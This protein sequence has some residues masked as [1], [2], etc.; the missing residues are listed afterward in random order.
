M[1]DY[2]SSLACL[3]LAA[4]GGLC[5]FIAYF[6]GVELDSP[7]EQLRFS[8]SSSTIFGTSLVVATLTVPIVADIV[9]DM[10]SELSKGI[11]DKK[12]LLDKAELVTLVAGLII[13]TI[14]S[15]IAYSVD[16]ISTLAI[17]CRRA[18]ILL[19]IGAILSAVCRKEAS[20]GFK[21]LSVFSM[22]LFSIG[23]PMSCF[24][25]DGSRSELYITAAV[26]SYAG[27]SIVLGICV[28]WLC[29]YKGLLT[30]ASPRFSFT[31]KV[32]STVEV[33]N[34]KRNC[35]SSDDDNFFIAAFLL[36]AVVWIVMTVITKL[37]YVTAGQLSSVDGLFAES[38]PAVFL[39]LSVIITMMRNVKVSAI[40]NLVSLTS[41][42]YMKSIHHQAIK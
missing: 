20:M 14:P 23:L 9:I 18:Q 8:L 7:N 11:H 29:K 35:Q 37:V 10:A 13:S 38:L 15:F 12:E 31:N 42:V 39:E 34:S 22:T 32:H 30:R 21:T 25:I 27:A 26:L 5:C 17:S 19:I 1:V 4:A 3:F 36:S 28:G 40:R 33:S 2:R 24:A 6:S 41:H 16:N